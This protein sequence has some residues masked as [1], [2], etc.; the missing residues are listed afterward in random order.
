M[1]CGSTATI[2]QFA[3]DTR[4]AIAHLLLFQG[5]QQAQQ[6]GHELRQPRGDLARQHRIRRA[7]HG[8]QRQRV[9]LLVVHAPEVPVLAGAPLRCKDHLRAKQALLSVSAAQQ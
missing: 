9:D 3:H 2:S 5:D 4:E 8:G 6:A 1:S 7:E